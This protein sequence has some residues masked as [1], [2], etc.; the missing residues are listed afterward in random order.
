MSP[1]MKKICG[2]LAQKH[3]TTAERVYQEMQDAIKEAYSKPQ[4]KEVE[5]YRARIPKSGGIP[6]P[7]ELIFFLCSELQRNNQDIR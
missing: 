4:P 2:K 6:S 5:E 3:H 1:V 7:E